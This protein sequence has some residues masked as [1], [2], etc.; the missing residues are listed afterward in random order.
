[1]DTSNE[2]AKFPP[3]LKRTLLT[4]FWIIIVILITKIIKIEYLGFPSGNIPPYLTWLTIPKLLL[5]YILFLLWKYGWSKLDIDEGNDDWSKLLIQLYKGLIRIIFIILAIFVL[6]GPYTTL[7]IFLLPGFYEYRLIPWIL[8]WLI[9]F[10]FSLKKNNYISTVKL[11]V[12]TPIVKEYLTD[13]IANTIVFAKNKWKRS[14]TLSKIIFFVLI[15][16][17]L[18]FLFK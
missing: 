14:T 2:T 18:Y 5:F 8:F 4:C 12:S 17:V 9:I 11:F 3:H 1:M 16:I 10:G 6:K 7:I 15:F 13:F